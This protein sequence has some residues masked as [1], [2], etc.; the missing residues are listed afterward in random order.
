MR[1]AALKKSVSVKSINPSYKKE[2][3]STK[4]IS[5]AYQPGD[6]DIL[7]RYAERPMPT[8]FEQIDRSYKSMHRLLGWP[9][10]IV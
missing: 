6:M 10:A 2:A 4:Q 5:A 3:I 8:A 9:S 1:T 7:E